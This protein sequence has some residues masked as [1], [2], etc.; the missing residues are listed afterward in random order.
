MPNSETNEKKIIY[1]DSQGRTHSH[2]VSLELHHKILQ[3]F[4]G[5]PKAILRTTGGIGL[6]VP[7]A[8][9]FKKTDAGAER[10]LIWMNCKDFSPVSERAAESVINRPKL[11]R[12]K[13]ILEGFKP[14]EETSKHYAIDFGEGIVPIQIL[15]FISI[16]GEEPMV[17]FLDWRIPA[18]NSASDAPRSFQVYWVPQACLRLVEN[19]NQ[20]KEN[21][22][23]KFDPK[24]AY[25]PKMLRFGKEIE[26]P[27]NFPADKFLARHLSQHLGEAPES[28][29]SATSTLQLSDEGLLP[30]GLLEHT[31]SSKRG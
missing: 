16:T 6:A 10:L 23:E 14:A 13:D 11:V 7:K 9:K 1:Y 24:K 5:G 22:V 27:S 21:C 8:I 28:E 31:W 19:L 25:I 29:T 17:A 20:A 15:K 26:V 12:V 4:N 30:F 18:V 2:L 3:I